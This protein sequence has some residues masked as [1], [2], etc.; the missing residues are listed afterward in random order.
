MQLRAEPKTIDSCGEKFENKKCPLFWVLGAHRVYTSDNQL[1]GNETFFTDRQEL[2]YLHFERAA[3]KKQLV[4]TI[5]VSRG[6]AQLKVSIEN[7]D[8]KSFELSSICLD[9]PITMN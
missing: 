4:V 8:L 1:K 7:F 9:L 3:L 2:N 6:A 5:I